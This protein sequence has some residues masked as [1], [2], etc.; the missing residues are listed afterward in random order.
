MSWLDFDNQ[1]KGFSAF[2]LTRLTV[3]ANKGKR[4]VYITSRDIDRNRGYCFPKYGTISG[5]YYN[6]VLFENG[7]SEYIKDIIECG[8]E[9]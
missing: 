4:I 7:K 3:R 9:A 2:R 1:E 8:I 6:Q 5:I